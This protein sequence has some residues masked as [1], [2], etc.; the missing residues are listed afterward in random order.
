MRLHSARVDGLATFSDDWMLADGLR[1]DDADVA[2]AA[3]C[4]IDVETVRTADETAG[5]T[6]VAVV[7]GAAGLAGV[8]GPGVFDVVVTTCD[9]DACEVLGCIHCCCS[10]GHRTFFGVL[11]LPAFMFL[12]DEDRGVAAFA[13]GVRGV[14]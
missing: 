12:M 6:D 14:R 9:V 7:E 13:L 4:R 3:V 8:E 2:A 5:D 11:V 1:G 10:S